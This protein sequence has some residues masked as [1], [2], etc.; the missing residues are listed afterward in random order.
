MRGRDVEGEG[1]ALRLEQVVAQQALQLR[2]RV[3]RAVP[4]GRPFGPGPHAAP[5]RGDDE[6][7]AAARHDAP[8]LPHH[9]P[10]VLGVLEP[11]DQEDPVDRIVGDRKLPLLAQDDEAGALPRPEA[12]ALRRRHHGE[13]PVR[14][15][16]EGAQ[17]RDGVAD[18]ADDL[19][20][21]VGPEFADAPTDHAARDLPEARIVELA[22]VDDVMVHGIGSLA[23]LAPVR[24][25]ARPPSRPVATEVAGP[26]PPS[27][28]NSSPP[29]RTTTST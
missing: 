25:P 24:Q 14:L 4:E 5:V 9:L 23:R 20:A 22:K 16:P 19:S 7:P 21:R 28:S 29:C 10:Q 3:G 18:A 17:E 12:A 6:Q 15:L 11:V 13:R 2:G 8:D 27:L 26:W 1:R